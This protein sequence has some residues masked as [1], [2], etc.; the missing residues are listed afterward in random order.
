MPVNGPSSLE[1]QIR[2]GHVSIRDEGLQLEPAERDAITRYFQSRVARTPFSRT[3]AMTLRLKGQQADQLA[4]RIHAANPDDAAAVASILESSFE[5]MA[6]Q[7]SVEH[8]TGRVVLGQ[9]FAIPENEVLDSLVVIGGSGIIA[10]Q[11][12]DLVLIGSSVELRA[13]ARVITHFVSVGSQVSLQ[14]GARL[15]AQE[16]TITF[17]SAEAFVRSM[18][19]RPFGPQGPA[20]WLLRVL[21]VFGSFVFAFALGMLYLHLAPRSEARANDYLNRRPGASFG[22]GVL[23]HLLLLPGALFLV[24][25][26]IGIF[27]LPLYFALFAAT[28][29][30]GHIIAALWLGA[31]IRPNAPF[32][33]ARALVVGLGILALIRLVPWLGGWVSFLATVAGQGA[34]FKSL[35]DRFRERRHRGGGMKASRDLPGRFPPGIYGPEPTPAGS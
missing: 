24:I 27:F 23:G 8:G 5:Q 12:N 1:I 22:I 33:G 31:R 21:W 26:A 28:F 32:T 20:S 10:G 18:A 19:E 6:G 11:V 30:L 9:N 29:V 2:E 25:T 15:E 14:P 13:S 17:P 34:L 7:T 16:V 35:L 4:S 3:G